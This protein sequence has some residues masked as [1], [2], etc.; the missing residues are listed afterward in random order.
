M[1]AVSG[2]Y[3]KIKIGASN[4]VECMGWTWNRTATTHPYRSCSTIDSG[5]DG[6]VY[7]KRV[8]GGSDSTGNIKGLQDP[9]D[10]IENYITEGSSVTLLL[11]WTASKYYSVPSVIAKLNVEDD[12]DGGQPIPWDADFESNGKW[13]IN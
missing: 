12:I 7:T 5:G 13:T 4:L 11:Y 3:G 8:T 6:K 1:G 9:S 10:Q 2:H